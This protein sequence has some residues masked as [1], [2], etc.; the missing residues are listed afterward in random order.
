M[1]NSDDIAHQIT[2]RN[3][4]YSLG[5][6]RAN[7]EL[8]H[9]STICSN[10]N[11]HLTLSRRRQLSYRNQSIDLRSKSMDWFLYDNGLRLERV[12]KFVSMACNDKLL[13]EIGL[14]IGFSELYDL[15]FTSY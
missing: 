13:W 3:N 5:I 8:E 14:E 2:G 15:S 12:L 10:H 11:K 1:G 7:L 4:D 6:P 9:M